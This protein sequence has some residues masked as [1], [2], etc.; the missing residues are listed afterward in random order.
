MISLAPTFPVISPIDFK[1]ADVICVLFANSV[2]A[3]AAFSAALSSIYNPPP[4]A[5]NPVIANPNGP[6]PASIGA[7]PESIDAAPSAAVTCGGAPAIPAT[8]VAVP[9]APDIL[10]ETLPTFSF[11]IP[12]LYLV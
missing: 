4:A 12:R 9:N 5:A 8:I 6:I 2:C 1:V 10:P 11:L 7:N 3:F